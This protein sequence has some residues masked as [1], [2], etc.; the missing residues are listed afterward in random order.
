MKRAQVQLLV[1]GA[2]GLVIAVI[3][4]PA[5]RGPS[6]QTMS[7]QQSTAVATH[8]SVHDMT[9]ETVADRSAKRAVQRQHAARLGWDR[10]PFHLDVVEEQIIELKLS[11]IIWDPAKPLALINGQ[12]VTVGANVAGQQVVAI[13]QQQVTVSDGTT[14]LQLQLVP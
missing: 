14:T 13:T 7:A 6:H 1:L 11:G 4:I 5:L 10:D 3:Y 2:L 8:D 9:I 12:M